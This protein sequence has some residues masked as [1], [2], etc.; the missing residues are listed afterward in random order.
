VLS[1]STYILTAFAL[2]FVI[3]G[4]FYALFP[5]QLRKMMALALSLPVSQ[6]RLFGISAVGMGFLCLWLISFLTG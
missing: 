3:E 1:F 4:L 2:V 5:D 6:L